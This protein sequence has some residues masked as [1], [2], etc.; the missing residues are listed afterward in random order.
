MGQCVACRVIVVGTWNPRSEASV[1]CIRES[2]PFFSL[3]MSIN[4]DGVTKKRCGGVIGVFFLVKRCALLYLYA[5][6]GSFSQAPYLDVH[7]EIDTLIRQVE[8]ILLRVL[9]LIQSLQTWS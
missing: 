4:A 8:Q 3:V 6:N 7:G 5:G 1:I 9:L 2:E